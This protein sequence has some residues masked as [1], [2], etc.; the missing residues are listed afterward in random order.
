MTKSYLPERGDI[1]FTNFDPSAGH[2]QARLRPA[3]VLTISAFNKLGGLALVM[4]I[5]STVRGS[6]FEVPI[7]TKKTTGVIL[8]HQLKMIDYMARGADFIERAPQAVLSHSLAKA[9]ALVA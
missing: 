1:I 3:L 9:R 5:T 4:P 8:C 7:N 6:G 2:E